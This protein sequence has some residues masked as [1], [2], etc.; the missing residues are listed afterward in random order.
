MDTALNI[1]LFKFV[2]PFAGTV[3]GAFLT[4]LLIMAGHTKQEAV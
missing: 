2:L 4:A 3:L 1:H